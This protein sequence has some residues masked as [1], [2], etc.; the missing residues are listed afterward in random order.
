MMLAFTCNFLFFERLAQDTSNFAIMFP[1]R[2]LRVVQSC[3]FNSFIRL[4]DQIT[5]TQ[6]IPFAKPAEQIFT[7]S[8][9]VSSSFSFFLI[10]F[11]LFTL[12]LC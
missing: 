8:L 2:R 3:K 1:C 6:N 12:P 9:Q 10:G 5:K 7:C 11:Y 4:S